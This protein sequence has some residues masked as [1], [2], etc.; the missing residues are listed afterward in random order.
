M[1][2][3]AQDALDLVYETLNWEEFHIIGQSMGGI[4]VQ[5]MVHLDNSST[6][7]QGQQRIRSAT[8]CNTFSSFYS[9]EGCPRPRTVLFMFR[10]AFA[11]LFQE[12]HRKV[13]LVVEQMFTREWLD[14]IVDE[15]ITNRVNCVARYGP[16]FE[17]QA[18]NLISVF[19][20]F[21]GMG[22]YYRSWKQFSQGMLA[23]LNGVLLIGGDQDNMVHYGNTLKMHQ[24]LIDQKRNDQ[25][26]QMSIMQGAGHIANSERADEFNQLL[27]C[28][29]LPRIVQQLQS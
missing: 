28:D 16:M 21:F 8:L 26:V 12:S 18:F 20:Q 11:Y 4:I 15:N 25:I 19:K 24:V 14:R 2:E 17:P 6:K 7:E 3:M 13:E 27:F 10:A 5:E 23:S 22:T 9:L 29:F 1:K